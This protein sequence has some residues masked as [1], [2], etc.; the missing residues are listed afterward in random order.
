MER[1]LMTRSPF[2][3][4]VISGCSILWR[5]SIIEAIEGES[6][7]WVGGT[8]V[9]DGW[10]GVFVVEMEDAMGWTSVD[11]G[12]EDF[13]H[14]PDRRTIITKRRINDM[15]LVFIFSSYPAVLSPNQ[16]LYS[17]FTAKKLIYALYVCKNQL[18]IKKLPSIID[19]RY[20]CLVTAFN[21]SLLSPYNLRCTTLKARTCSAA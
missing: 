8:G 9:A 17:M 15:V 20:S 5:T 6:G 11:A 10:A 12:I 3:L 1:F 2:L 13:P 4:L 16:F 19:G 21:Y 14:A 7:V 18:T